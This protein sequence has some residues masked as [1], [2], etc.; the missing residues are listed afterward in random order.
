MVIS[1]VT[2]KSSNK[3]FSFNF[4][5]LFS[6]SSQHFSVHVVKLTFS[7]FS[8]SSIRVSYVVCRKS[9]SRLFS[10]STLLT[11]DESCFFSENEKAN[12]PLLIQWHVFYNRIQVIVAKWITYAYICAKIILSRIYMG[13]SS[14]ALVLMIIWHSIISYPSFSESQ[15]MTAVPL[16]LLI[17][18]LSQ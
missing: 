1:Y 6:V 12:E 9:N 4:I 3:L 17:I 16:A 14:K 10:C 8:N 5:D 7:N 13:F 11:A 18:F 15:N 2:A